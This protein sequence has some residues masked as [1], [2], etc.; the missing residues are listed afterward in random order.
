M[1]L[2][3]EDKMC[4]WVSSLSLSLSGSRMKLA[5]WNCNGAFRKKFPAIE[6]LG[7]DLLIV[8]ECENPAFSDPD[9]QD[10]CS[11]YK[12]AGTSKHKGIGV[13]TRNDVT[14]APLDL[15]DGGNRLFL[16][17]LVDDVFNLL[18]VW[19]QNA[20]SHQYIGQL[21]NYLKIHLDFLAEKPLVIVGDFNSHPRWDKRTRDWNHSDVVHRLQDY[22]INSVY[23]RF[24]QLEAGE[25]KH[26]TLFL[27]R[28]LEKP[29]HV[30]YAFVNE[31][32][33]SDSPVHVGAPDAWLHLSDHMPLT[34]WISR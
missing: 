21:W 9:Y 22:S 27:Q 32:L 18:A 10:W 3:F 12:W 11:N 26:P 14:L 30:D 31:K 6:D 7:A 16:P 15:D 19:T 33:I 17:L 5:T 24:Y 25:E 29:Y 4:Q 2:S 23:H 13:F 28:N 20:K 1:I 34:F 8:Q